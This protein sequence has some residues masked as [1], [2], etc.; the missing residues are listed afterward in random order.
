MTSCRDEL[1][2]D[3][4]LRRLNSITRLSTIAVAL[5][6]DRTR[7]ELVPFLAENTDD[8]DEVL[9]AQAE[10]LGT[11]VPY[12]GG[13]AYAHML[14]PL[15]ETLATVE[16]TVVR[17]K[18]VE[19]LCKVGSQLPDSSVNEYLVPLIKVLL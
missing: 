8:E 10:Q 3:E 14:L 4:P 13:P 2:S 7:T 12:V 16:E 11:F 5:G 15:L 19:S 6:E 18:A 17:D 1:K 9:L